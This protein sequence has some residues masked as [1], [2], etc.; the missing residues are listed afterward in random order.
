MLVT[1]H[2]KNKYERI[3]GYHWKKLKQYLSK[4]CMEVEY[5]EETSS[6]SAQSYQN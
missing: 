1:Y 6:F 2:G 5:E 4:Y 3:T